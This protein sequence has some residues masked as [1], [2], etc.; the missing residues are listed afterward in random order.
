MKEFL[1]IAFKTAVGINTVFPLIILW[2][3]A[4]VI[5]GVIT[6]IISGGNFLM[7]P[8]SLVASFLFSVLFF[9]VT[10]LTDQ[11]I[12]FNFQKFLNE[13]IVEPLYDTFISN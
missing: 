1:K 3:F 7:F 2:L 11:L 4:G 9:F 8:I 10:G 6:T 12:A 13:T 5:V